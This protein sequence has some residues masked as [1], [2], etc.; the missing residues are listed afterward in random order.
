MS[1]GI[2]S[3]H[4]KRRRSLYFPGEM[5]QEIASEA[6]RLSRSRSRVG[7]TSVEGRPTRR[8]KAPL[9]Q[10]VNAPTRTRA[11]HGRGRGTGLV[12]ERH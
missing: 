9:D 3:G 6:Q 12:R 1:D 4:D 7:A 11:G 2:G 8:Q 10:S 5:L